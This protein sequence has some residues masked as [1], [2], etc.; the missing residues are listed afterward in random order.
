M[1]GIA[2]TCLLFVVA[3]LIGGFRHYFKGQ[4]HVAVGVAMAIC[5]LAPTWAF[6]KYGPLELDAKMI[7]GAILL[8]AYCLHPKGMLRFPVQPLDYIFG[9]ILLTHLVAEAYQGE[10]GVTVLLRAIGEW[11]VPYLGGRCL[12]LY[13]GGVSSIAP[14]FNGVTIILMTGAVIESLTG[15]NLWEAAW[16]PM[17]DLVERNRDRRYGWLYRATGP[18]RHP[19]FLGVV[20]LLMIP[21]PIVV[22]ERARTRLGVALGWIGI[23]SVCIG[24][25]ATVSRGP[26]LGLIVAGAIAAVL[27]WP[28]FRVPALVAGLVGLAILVTGWNRVLSIVERT[29]T[30]RGRGELVELDG[31]A[32]IYSGTRNRIF[33][34][35]IYGPLVVRSG[36]LGFGTTA[37]SSFPP[38]IPGLPASARAAEALGIVD[39]SYLLFG[40]R[41]GWLGA[42]LLPLALLTA[43][44]AAM[45][46]RPSA[47][48]I[49][50]PYSSAFLTAMASSLA[51]CALEMA[52][53]FCSY[54]FMFW[55][56]FS[57]GLVA[58]TGS[59][60]RR[61]V[62]GDYIDDEV[63]REP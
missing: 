54:E 26:L 30:V 9:G 18:V 50:Y 40:L 58:G 5:L 14:W 7:A 23:V 48:L 28:T 63:E 27:R 38:N 32:E 4:P 3:A 10:F 21:W 60:G 44:A 51:G 17:D 8:I 6:F 25:V 59:L 34:W 15:V 39:N 56:I 20:F 36:P 49:S 35:K 57:C 16:A 37:V 55:V 62:T 61:L 42:A 53:V 47:G 46:M 24:I 41:F 11:S 13:R 43:I 29:D 33:V 45:A 31:N 12:G 22:I 52:T 1:V 2:L 19:I